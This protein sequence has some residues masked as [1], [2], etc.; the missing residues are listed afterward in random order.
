LPLIR[1]CL[2]DACE[3]SYPYAE[4][5][6][7]GGDTLWGTT[8]QGGAGDHGTIFKIDTSSANLT[9]VVEFTDNG[10]TNKG[11]FPSAKLTSVGAGILWGTTAGGGASGQGTVF[12]VNTSTGALTTLVEFTGDGATNKGA[13][14][15]AELVNDG[16]GYIWGTTL[17]GG[18]FYGTVFK[19]NAISGALTTLVEFT[20]SGSQSNTGAY[21][22]KGTLL[23]HIDGH[24]YGTTSDGG[25]DGGGTIFRLRR[26]PKAVTLAS[27]ARTGTAAMLNGTVNPN[28]DGNTSVSFKYGTSPT[29]V[30]AST[31]SGSNVSNGGV[32]SSVSSPI[33][34]LTVGTTYYYRILASNAGNEVTQQGDILS[35]VAAD[36][37]TQTPV[38]TSPAT[39]AVTKSPVSVAFDLPE[40]A[41]NGT[42]TLG[43]TGSAART[44]V[45][46]SSQGT[47][48]PHSFSFN[49]ANPTATAAIVSISGGTT[50]PDG[51]YTVT[52]SY[53][54]VLSNPA[55][56]ISS[57]NVRIDTTPPTFSLP[58]NITVMATS[59]AGA[60][61]A[62]SANA[63]DTG[64]SGISIS[65]F[66]PASASTFPLGLTT[67]NASATD[68]AGNAASGSFTVT[69]QNNA[70]TISN[71]LDRSVVQN[72]STGAVGFTAGDVETALN[73]LSITGSSSNTSLVPD[74]NIM[75]GGS[76]A[77]RTVTVT[78]AANQKGTTII[79]LTVSDGELSA[80]DSFLLTVNAPEI[81]VEQ[82]T[83]TGI[84]DGAA[85]TSFGN[86]VV[87]ASSLPVTYTVRNTGSSSL[88]GLILTKDGSHSADF[89]LSG[90]GAATLAPGAIT[91][92]TVT[93]KPTASGER[94]A[95]LHIGSNDT[96]ENP[97]D[98]ALIGTGQEPPVFT[99]QP[100]SQIVLLGQTANFNP[101]VTGDPVITYQ[102]KKGTANIAIA[103]ADEFTIPVTKAADAAAYSVVADNPIGPRGS[104]ASMEIPCALLRFAASFV[105][106]PHF[107]MSFPSSVNS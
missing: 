90:L 22:D 34:G 73:S 32:V 84:Q 17:N 40:V 26:G 74:T 19:V 7:V 6:S 62:Y 94:S 5:V 97:F 102:W 103:T 9:T 101:T 10:L 14:P 107:L 2:W 78:P 104:V 76:G 39:N 82:P 3:G 60:N 20:G 21:P 83:G 96:D 27:S 106:P 45:L 98:I 13:Q 67:V 15:L 85:E 29:L 36:A 23:K 95:G 25:P 57:S 51:V 87:P 33:S 24:F 50:L 12:K 63:L 59:A 16:L 81:V 18:G 4:L 37:T 91:T 68:T 8:S 86:V 55:A 61:V 105:G 69:V 77:N 64:G 48:G 52:L 93:F 88:S 53:Q 43:F 70:P 46:G 100:Q 66:A 47:A 71:I 49:P 80:S 89:L 42:L 99:A 41:A 11:R 1:H 30:G 56:T 79:T 31:V 58:S 92:F 75:F 72:E 28:S 54:D 38:M 44:L 35:F 65:N